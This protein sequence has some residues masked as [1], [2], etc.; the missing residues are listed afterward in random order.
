MSSAE[1]PVITVFSL[2]IK[3]IL[4]ECTSYGQ[5]RHQYYSF[6]D[7]KNMFSN[8]P[9]QNTLNFITKSIYMINYNF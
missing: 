4:T 9:S 1:F 5:T 6:T 3:H 2:L 7:I 8:T